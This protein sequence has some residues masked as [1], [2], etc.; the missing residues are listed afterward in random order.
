MRSVTFALGEFYH[1]YNRGTEKRTIF[2]NTSDYK[3]FVQ[4]LYLANSTVSISVRNIERSQVN[5]F[6]YVRKEPIVAIGTWCLMPNHFHILA[7][8]LVENGLSKF[9]KKLTTGY[10]MYF[11]K[12]YDRN[13]SLFQGNF[14]AEH[15]DVDEYLK[16]LY[17]YIHLN[18]VKLIDPTWKEKGIKDAQKS[19]DFCASFPYSSLQDYLGSSRPEKAILNTAPFP[20]YFQTPDKI[21]TELFEW[22]NYKNSL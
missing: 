3:R 8:P 7:T 6:E 17:A 14:R 11:N 5:L 12:K 18:P 4:L 13:G 9:M 21:K 15:A 19:Y 16:Y 2:L 20:E 1:I 22:L 10:S